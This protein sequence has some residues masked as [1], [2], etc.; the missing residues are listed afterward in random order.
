MFSLKGIDLFMKVIFLDFDGVINNW[1]NLD[2]V[3]KNNVINLL[4][5]INITGAKI[6]ATTSN[7]YSFQ[8]YGIEYEHT[9][10]Y[11][12]V[13]ILK[14]YG[15]EIFDVTPLVSKKRELEIKNTSRNRTIL[16]F[17]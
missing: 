12:Y 13:K 7:K 5:I 2:I 1:T 17:R 16:N 3:D 8:A 6:V 11:N 9:G 14:K 10:Y 15:I 4:K